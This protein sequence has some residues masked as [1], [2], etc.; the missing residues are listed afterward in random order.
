MSNVTDL[1]SEESKDEVGG[2]F[3]VVSF[4]CRRR[5]RAEG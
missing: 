5:W 1:R 4:F 2:E 3:A